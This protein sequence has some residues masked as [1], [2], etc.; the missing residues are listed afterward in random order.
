MLLENDFE[1]DIVDIETAFLYGE[2]EEEIYLKIP[3]GL[4][5]YLEN[6]FV[7]DDFF[8]LDKA[9]YGLVQAARQ[10]YKKFIKIINEDLGFK[11]C[12]ADACLLQRE[13]KLGK[14]VVFVYVDDTMCIGYRYAIDQLK[15]E[16]QI[17]F[18]IKDEGKMNE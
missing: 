7:K 13:T 15:T 18:N 11:K 17:Y 10:Y 3:E 2:L 9:M 16:L 14:V 5:V 1:A 12:L 4:D 8:V 6:K